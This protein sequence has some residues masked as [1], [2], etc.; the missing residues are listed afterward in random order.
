MRT[1]T[2]SVASQKGGCGKTTLALHLA[3]AAERAG[4]ATV[5]IDMDPQGTAEAW[6]EWRK[7]APPLV[8]PAKAPTLTRT[9]ERAVV[10]GA[11]FVVIDTPPIAEAEARAA[12][13]AA[14]LILVPCRPNAFDLHSVKT[15]AEIPILA[16]KATFA[17]FN[18]GPPSAPKLYAETTGL[19]TDF[20]LKVAPVRLSDR[21]TFRHATGSG[22]SAQ[23][24]EP[25]G[26]A[27][28]EVDA[29]WKWVCQQV[30]M[31]T[32]HRVNTSAQVLA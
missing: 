24:I 23:E 19:V 28:A 31:S 15:T 18:A 32:R 3:V 14:D 8:I 2:V 11:E 5:I 1:V 17:V 4:Y 25:V 21:A 26:K 30:G 22:Q 16:E 20:G 12:A 10:H 13:K 27:A 6:Y 29:L 9:L 7:E